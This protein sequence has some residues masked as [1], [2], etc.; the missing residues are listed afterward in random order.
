MRAEKGWFMVCR[1]S[2]KI[3][4]LNRNHWWGRWLFPLMGLAALIWFLVRVLPKPSR[5]EYPCQ[6][7]AAPLALGGLGWFL[8]LFGMVSAFRH[9]RQF[10]RQH[11]YAVAAA[12]LGIALA[13]GLT[14]LRQ[15]ENS[16]LAEDTGIFTLGPGDGPNQPI[17]VAR[18]LFPGRVAWSYDLGA[19]N[20]DGTSKYWFSTNFNDQTKIT[21]ILN[22]VICSVAGQSSISNAWDTL[23]RSKNG[24]PSYV[25]GEKICVKLNLN[26]GGKNS[27]QIDASP[28][29]VYALLDGLVNQFGADQADITLCDPDRENQCSVISNYCGAQF[30]NVN[31]DRHL[32]GFVPN[33]FSYSFTGPGKGPTETALAK[34][35]LDTKYL[36]TMAI[37]KRHCTPS[38]TYHDPT[39]KTDYGN[40]S[41]TMIFK[42]CWGII[43]NSRSS[44]HWLLHDWDFP[45]ASYNQLVDI[46]GSTNIN[47]KTVLNIL[48]GL[49]SGDR[50]N[51]PPHKW[52]I[53]PFN[54]HWP[55]SF[56]ASQDPVALESVG[57]D[58]L[59]SEMPLIKNADRHLREAALAN[60]PPSGTVYKPDGVRLESLGTQEHWNNAKDMQYSR[61]LG[62][63]KG[64]ELVK[65]PEGT[66]TTVS[67]P[68]SAP[69]TATVAANQ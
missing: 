57:L 60:N 14:V 38:A 61:N 17:G 24:G 3:V 59:M 8:S 9:A 51:S 54:G 43:G 53:A 13:C 16:A 56:F 15:N 29:S 33:S 44:Q 41:V 30:P 11:R 63:G 42:S 2:G 40:A 66:V 4:G 36:I 69:D 12:C 45:E 19:C 18:G 23:F 26:N 47:G 5:A 65:I 49:Y 46:F 58:F 6:R 21:K 62:T 34:V 32:G 52:A 27:N 48:D 10:I 68:V 37:L 50:W 64:I 25:K 67:A 35:V 22:N 7:V 20:W 55:S 39:D 31:Y 1:K 28:Q